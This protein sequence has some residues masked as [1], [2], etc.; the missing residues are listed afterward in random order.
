MNEIYFNP[1]T[2]RG[3]LKATDGVISVQS[4][5]LRQGFPAKVNSPNLLQ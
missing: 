2:H 5:R 1:S 4:T 3:K